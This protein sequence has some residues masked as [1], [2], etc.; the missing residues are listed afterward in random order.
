MSGDND[1]CTCNSDNQY[2]VRF[3]DGWP[4]TQ[5]VREHKR[6]D[7]TLR[8]M[9]YDFYGYKRS[10]EELGGMYHEESCGSNPGCWVL[11]VEKGFSDLLLK[12]VANGSGMVS[13]R[14]RE[15]LSIPF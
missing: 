1:M 9:L 10:G 5:F 6:Y 12:V 3:L 7:T 14:Y 4:V 11:P 8:G 15:A 13:S 2:A